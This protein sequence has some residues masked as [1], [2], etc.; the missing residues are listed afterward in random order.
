MIGHSIQFII[1]TH[2][3]AIDNEFKHTMFRVSMAQ[4]LCR[5]RMSPQLHGHKPPSFWTMFSKQHMRFGIQ[6]NDWLLENQKQQYY[7]ESSNAYSSID[8]NSQINKN[9][10]RK[11][12]RTHRT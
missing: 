1:Y 2:L 11:G 8:N 7:A 12:P 10:E 5:S 9:Q 4:K 6:V 3:A